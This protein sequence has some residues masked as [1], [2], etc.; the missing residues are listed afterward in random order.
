V[1]RYVTR[2]GYHLQCTSPLPAP[3]DAGELESLDVWYGDLGTC[4]EQLVTRSTYLITGGAGFIGANV[5]HRLLERGEEVVV[6]DN[7][8]RPGTRR[9]LSW[10]RARHGIDAVRLIEADVRDQ[11]AV[12]AAVRVA[13]VVIHLAGQVAVTTSIAAPREDFEVNAGGTLNLLEAAR[14][15]SRCPIV[16]YASTNKVYGS[17]SSAPV[18]EGPTS[19]RYR[20]LDKG[21]S[22]NQPLDLHSPYGCSK[23]CGDAYVR[24]YAR[25]YDLPGVVLRQS[26]VYGPLQYGVEDQGWVAWLMIA[27]LTEQPI[28]ICGDGK[29]V[30]DLLWV[31]DLVT[32][33]DRV[34][35]NITITAGEVFNIGGGPDNAVSV[36]AEYGP[37][38]E[39]L[40]GR[41]IPVR[42]SDWRAGDQRIFVCDITKARQVLGWE[43]TVYWRDGVARL[44]DWVSEHCASTAAP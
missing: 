4:E 13:D 20:D 39:Q 21:V 33:Y 5:V 11:D 29:Q 6:Y 32:A 8:S 25:I 34:I 10:L 12:D 35:D 22:E 24:D 44:F 1:T 18:V 28:T 17:M 7:L 31:D 27:A 26:C 16:L 3:P 2:D 40:L 41:R 23:G 14:G 38:L 43:P 9:N 42:Y 36:W 19:Y 15:S 30:R 37:V